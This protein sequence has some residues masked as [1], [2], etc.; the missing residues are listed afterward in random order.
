MSRITTWSHPRSLVVVAGDQ[1][2]ALRAEQEVAAVLLA[3]LPERGEGAVVS[4]V[5]SRG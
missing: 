2:P 4:D 3:P 1:L 5:G